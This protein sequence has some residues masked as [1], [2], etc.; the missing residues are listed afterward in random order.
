MSEEITVEVN[1]ELVDD[2]AL[3]PDQLKAI[4]EARRKLFEKWFRVAENE[5]EEGAT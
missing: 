4:T 3:P 2:T 1:I 5:V